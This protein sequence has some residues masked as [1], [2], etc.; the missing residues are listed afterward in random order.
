MVK[1]ATIYL[2]D[3]SKALKKQDDDAVLREVHF[4]AA[5]FTTMEK[6][7][8]DK[9]WNAKYNES[10]NE[11]D[12]GLT[13]K[14]GKTV[15]VTHKT[16]GKELVIIDKPNVRKEYEKIGFYAEGNVSEVLTRGGAIELQGQAKYLAQGLKDMTKSY[17]KKDWAQMEEEV[18][19]VVAKAKLMGDIVKQKR[20]QESVNESGIMYRAGVKKYGLEGMKKIQS[21][22][23]KGL[24][25]AEIG[26]IKDKYDKKRKKSE[27]VDEGSMEKNFKWAKGKELKAIEMMIDM[28]AEGISAVVKNYKKN[29]KAFKQFVKDISRMKGMDESVEPKGNMAKI[30][31]IVKD[32]QHAK[33]GG[34]LVDMF[35]AS[36]LVKIFDAVN[37]SNKEKL[38]KMNMKK[39]SYVLGKAFK[40]KVVV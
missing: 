29:P 38:N 30:F 15:K 35:S 25:H 14:K 6:M 37:D 12:L 22:A 5:Q 13:Y 26:K 39:L 7:L 1:H 18:D 40:D 9:K 11:D 2:R 23:G 32:K 24:G 33:I 31:K 21:A 8:K 19:Y 27:S 3:L 10:V 17:K 28:E 16:S 20:Y 4:L 34:M 36:A